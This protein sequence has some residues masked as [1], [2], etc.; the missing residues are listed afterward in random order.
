MTY[1][2]RMLRARHETMGAFAPVGV[3][4]L[5][6]RVYLLP[7]IGEPELYEEFHFDEPWNS[8]HNM[9]LLPRM[10]AVFGDGAENTKTRFQ[11]FTGEGTFFDGQQPP[12]LNQARDGLSSTI[13][14]VVT[15]P[16]KAIPWTQPD[17]V[18]FVRTTVAQ[19][20]GK[21]QAIECIMADGRLVTFPGNL[22]SADLDGFVTPAGNEVVD[23][24]KFQTLPAAISAAPPNSKIAQLQRAR[25]IMTR[26]KT[27][28]TGMMD[29]HDAHITYPVTPRQPRYFDA[30][31]RPKLS[32]RVHLLPYIEQ[33]PLF[34][35]FHLDEPWDSAHNMTLLEKM[36]S[37]FGDPSD[38]AGTTATRFVV[39]TGPA[40]V[41]AGKEAPK[42]RGITDGLT[43]TALV[44]Q[45]GAN[46]AVPWTKP[47]D[48]ELDPKAPKSL[49]GKVATEETIFLVTADG[50]VKALK[51]TIPD[52]LFHA[53]LT[54]TGGERVNEQELKSYTMEY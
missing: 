38:P 29:Y 3:K 21:P 42:Q 22:S 4:N 17:D 5:S 7:F 50:A 27:L 49:L 28:A 13:L 48:A 35:Q 33:E 52:G 6:W 44:V 45:V 36:P 30:T 11:V 2:S 15:A 10:P 8:P 25:T 23:V 34:K 54:A 9:T 41:Y 47:D 32:W 53:L 24:G 26:L 46:K 18:P 12:R 37:V 16:E 43:Y 39:V 20:L 40:T 51:S 31:G 1:L 19:S 14:V